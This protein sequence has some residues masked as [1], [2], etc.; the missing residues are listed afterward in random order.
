MS[1]NK[2]K[3]NNPFERRRGNV[4]GRWFVDN[5]VEMNICGCRWEGAG[6]RAEQR[7]RGGNPQSNNWS[8]R[9]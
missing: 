3:L 2:A 9:K 6:Q 7:S 4:F 5:D 1:L 8:W